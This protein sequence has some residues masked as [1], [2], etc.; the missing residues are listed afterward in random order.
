MQKLKIRAKD[1]KIGDKI[2]SSTGKSYKITNLIETNN[3]IIVLLDGD[4][5]IDFKLYTE[6]VILTEKKYEKTNPSRI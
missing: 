1:L 3:R 5:E 6:I 2:L 4:M